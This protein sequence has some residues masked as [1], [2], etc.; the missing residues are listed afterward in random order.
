MGNPKTC[1][2]TERQRANG[3][4]DQRTLPSVFSNSTSS[5]RSHISVSRKPLRAIIQHGTQGHRH[6]LGH[7]LPMRLDTEPR[8]LVARLVPALE[9]LSAISRRCRIIIAN[10]REN[11]GVCAFRMK[12][13]EA[14]CAPGFLWVP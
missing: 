13:I 8:E 11:L 3:N 9:P 7:R 5:Q 10:R 6:Y 4:D 1:R 2:E 12:R 14:S